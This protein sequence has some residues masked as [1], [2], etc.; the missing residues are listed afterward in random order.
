MFSFVFFN[1]LDVIILSNH[2]L[3][4]GTQ[5]VSYTCKINIILHPVFIFYSFYDCVFIGI[6]MIKL[7]S[8]FLGKFT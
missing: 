7:E 2:H 3:L 6:V 5:R 4:L 1:Q 8:L